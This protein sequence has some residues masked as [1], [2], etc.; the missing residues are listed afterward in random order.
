M[1]NKKLGYI[2]IY[3]SIKTHWIWEDPVKLRWWLDILLSVNYLDIVQKVNINFELFECSRGQSVKTL[4]T[5]SKEW[6]VGKDTVRNF[7]KILQKDNM[8]K[9]ENL[10]K[11]TRIT[12]CNYDEYQPSLHD[13]QTTDKRQPN[14]SQTTT[15]PNNKDNKDNKDNNEINIDDCEIPENQKQPKTTTVKIP[16]NVFEV[17]AYFVENGYSEISAEKFFNYYSVSEWKDSKGKQVKNWKLK[18][19]QIWF[20]P[21]N[22]IKKQIIYPAVCR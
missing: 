7:F 4:N 16:I 2:S 5:W 12:V 21:E 15:D 18:A 8:I 22:E 11:C 6:K 3:R 20:K 9:I 19:Q 13:R 1:E 14:A 17:T 10:Q